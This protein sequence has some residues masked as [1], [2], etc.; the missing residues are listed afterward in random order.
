MIHAD[1]IGQAVDDRFIVG[2]GM[3]LDEEGRNYPDMYHLGQ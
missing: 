3:D 2:Y 1:Y